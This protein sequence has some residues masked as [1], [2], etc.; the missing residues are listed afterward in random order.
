MQDT[1]SDYSIPVSAR[2]PLPSAVFLCHSPG[3]DPRSYWILLSDISSLFRP[4]RL[5]G[6]MP[7]DH[8]RP[9]LSR[10]SL[11]AGALGLTA[12]TAGGGLL[13]GCSGSSNASGAT[14]GA[15]DVAPSVTL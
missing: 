1:D 2:R 3:Q 4:S 5:G 6:T 8:A 15:G 14:G 11:I 13:S 12:A 10:R 9:E 7:N